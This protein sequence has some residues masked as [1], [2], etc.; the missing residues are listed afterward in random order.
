MKSIKL[1]IL[2]LA[3]SLLLISILAISISSVLGTYNSTMYALEESMAATI[4]ATADM[5]EVQLESYQELA[6]Q[7]AVDPILSQEVPEEGDETSDGRSYASVRTEILDYAETLKP[8]HDIESID[9]LSVD[10]IALNN[11]MDFSSAPFFTVPRDTGEPYVADP[12]LSPETG[13]L[14]MPVT[15]PIIRNGNFEGVALFAVNPVIFSEIIAGVAIGEGST[16]TIIDQNGNTIAFN[17]TRLVFDA[18]N[19]INEAKT[20][21]SLQALADMEQR[22]ISGGEGFDSVHYDDADWFSAYTQI[23]DSNGW[24]IYILAHQEVFLAQ[25][26]TS[27]IVILVLSVV[28]IVIAAFVIIFVSNKIS[29]PITVCVDRLNLVAQGD[30]NSPMPEVNTSDETG[31]LANSTA[32]IVNSVSVMINDLNYVLSEVAAG[33][34]TVQSRAKEYYIGDFNSLS[35]SLEQIVST[36]SL[37]MRKINDVSDQVSNGNNQVALG[38]QSLA[39]GAIEQASAVEELSATIDDIAGKIGETAHDS[40]SAKMANEKAQQ[41]LGV[42]NEQM[43]EMVAAMANISE[44]SMQISNIIKAIDDIAFQTNI[45]SLN[46]S[47]EAARAGTAGR[48]FAVVADEVRSLATKSAQSA[49][50]TA[51]LIEETVAAVEVGNKIAASTSESINI[52]IDSANELSS[53]V[54]SIAIAS[55]TQSEGAKQVSIG[56]EQI[57]A[58]VQTNSATAEESAATSEELS[59]QSQILKELLSEFTLDK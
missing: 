5:M 30:L 29:K 56:I 23:D 46:A 25:M 2:T 53:L 27:I 31:I 39:Q 34:F 43:Q 59:G 21:P 19:T 58:V 37:T 44:K 15:A 51:A 55:V 13:E 26:I 41:A 32:S 38:A 7:F 4:D 28:I 52:A 36:L 10:G 9:I 3:M 6:K 17:D 54:D 12:T 20:D 47:V 57:S 35:G 50:D 42:S 45:L 14:T 49:S 33:N 11:G 8:I 16:V 18:F 48:S 1:K 40:Q 22:L 24:G